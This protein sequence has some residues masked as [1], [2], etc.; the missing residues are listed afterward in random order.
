MHHRL[1]LISPKTEDLIAFRNL[2]VRIPLG[3]NTDED[4]IRMGIE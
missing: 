1:S 4:W 3:T 2:G